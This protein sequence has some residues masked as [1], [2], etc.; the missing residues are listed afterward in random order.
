MNFSSDACAASP[1]VVQ[2]ARRDHATRITILGRAD[3]SNRDRFRRALSAVDVTAT[4][5]VELA[6]ARLEFCDVEAASE[7]V[8]FAHEVCADDVHVTV[9]DAT[10][11]VVAML[12]LLDAKGVVAMPAPRSE[13]RKKTWLT[14]DVPPGQVTAFIKLMMALDHDGVAGPSGP[15]HAGDN[16]IHAQ[17]PAAVEVE[18]QHPT[19]DGAAGHP[20]SAPTPGVSGARSSA[21]SRGITAI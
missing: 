15:V 1:L 17:T 12:T 14:T 13:S 10:R 4:S 2:I 5:R 8:A 18:H 19:P 11:W 20:S 16:G 21:L 3:G 7:L 9:V 6:L